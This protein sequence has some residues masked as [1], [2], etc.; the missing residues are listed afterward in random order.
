MPIL[1]RRV[2]TALKCNSFGNENRKE[3]IKDCNQS[4]YCTNYLNYCGRE[5]K[6]GILRMA[7]VNLN[8]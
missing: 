6:D 1:Y 5:K 7:Y 4:E 3:E 8:A 2:R